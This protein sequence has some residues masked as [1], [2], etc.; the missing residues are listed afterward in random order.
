MRKMTCGGVLAVAAVAPVMLVAFGS[1]VAAQQLT[2]TPIVHASVQVEFGALVIQIDPWSAGDLSRA[3][4]ADLILITDDPIHH[5]DPKAIQQLRKPGAPVVVP[6][7][8]RSKFP[9]GTPL[10]NGET[11]TLA[12]ISVEAIAAYDIK[13]GEPS[14]PKGKANGYVITLGGK[15]IYF[16]GVTECVPEIRALKNIDV[17]FLPMNLPLDRMLPEAT[18][19][20][21]GA[22]TPKTVYVNHYDQ[23]YAARL[24][25]PNARAAGGGP[26]IAASL[27]LLRDRL[28]ALSI[29]F[30]DGDWYPPRPAR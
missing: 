16:A 20:C 13:P 3:K 21:V 23:A 19:E 5:L 24:T 18:A 26:D 4:A 12:G 30:K 6:T 17:A 25:N 28:K 1:A 27:Q 15:R 7:A 9:E 2:I 11:T 8:S 22:F 10:A 29:E 14:H